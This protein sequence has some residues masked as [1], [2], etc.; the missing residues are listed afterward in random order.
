MPVCRWQ[1][2][3]AAASTWPE[4]RPGLGNFNRLFSEIFLGAR[5]QKSNRPI[6]QPRS[7]DIG[8]QSGLALEGTSKCVNAF[9][10]EFL[11]GLLGLFVLDE[12]VFTY[13]S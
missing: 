12:S 4:S 1:G 11:W 8:E 2:K 13:L 6:S 9:S 5:A 10:Q 3:M 7:W